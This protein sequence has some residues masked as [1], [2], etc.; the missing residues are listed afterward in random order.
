[1]LDKLQKLNQLGVKAFYYSS[2]ANFLFTSLEENTLERVEQKLLG[3]GI[4]KN[5]IIKNVFQ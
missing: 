1:M 2:H 3:I 5:R 4:P